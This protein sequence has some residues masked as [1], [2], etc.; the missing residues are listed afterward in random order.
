MVALLMRFLPRL[1]DFGHFIM[2]LWGKFIWETSQYDG[3][4]TVVWI[5]IPLQSLINVKKQPKGAR[6]IGGRLQWRNQPV[7]AAVRPNHKHSTPKIKLRER[8]TRK[9]TRLRS[10]HQPLRF[11]LFHFH[12]ALPP[13]PHPRQLS[14]IQK[15][16]DDVIFTPTTNVFTVHL[17][18][19]D[20][21]ITFFCDLFLR[22][23]VSKPCRNKSCICP[24]LAVIILSPPTVIKN[25]SAP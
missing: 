21:W 9:M 3:R 17:E 11:H 25:G 16:Y 13:P 22:S 24:N 6:S 1:S 10:H 23:R 15:P 20:H 18:A 14:S 7:T 5:K 4:T 2:C 12:P 19:P 8:S